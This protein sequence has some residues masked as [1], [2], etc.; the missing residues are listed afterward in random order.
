LTVDDL[1]FKPENLLELQKKPEEMSYIEL[2]KFVDEMH[3]IGAEARKWVVELYF[4]ISYPFANF[5][6]VLFGAPLA[7]R[8]R[9]SGSAVGIGI[10]LLVCFIYFLFI[11]TG[12]VMGHQGSLTPL[13]G[14]WFGNIIFAAAGLFT[15]FKARM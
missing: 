12:Q 1:R 7:A 4:K 6:I 15:L 11:R 9:R 8:K 14:A 3:A 13:V 10:S 5:I 2:D